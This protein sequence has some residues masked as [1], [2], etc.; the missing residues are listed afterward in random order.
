MNVRYF[1]KKFEGEYLKGRRGREKGIVN[2]GRFVLGLEKGIFL[3]MG[4]VR[5]DLKME[6]REGSKDRKVKV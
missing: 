2:R 1:F 4:E 3:K 5:F 6:I